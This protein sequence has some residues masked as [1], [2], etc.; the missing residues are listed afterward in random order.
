MTKIKICGLT[1]LAD[2]EAVNAAHPDYIGFVFA[3]SKRQLDQDTARRLKA[4]LDPGIQAVG[5]FVNHP[6]T[7]IIELAN[8]GIIDLIQ[9]HGDEDE[10]TVRRLQEQTGRPVIRAFRISSPAD[11]KETAADYRLFDTY[12]P[13]QYGGSG[14]TFNWELLQGITGDFFLAGGL[15]CSNIEAAINQVRPYCVDLSS[16]VETDGV[17]DRDKIIEIVERIRRIRK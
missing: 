11:I 12:D 7:E 1:R 17:K 15:N 9:L 6:V 10:A 14:A 8:Q 13:N 3:G 5:V 16:G 2:I 4:Q